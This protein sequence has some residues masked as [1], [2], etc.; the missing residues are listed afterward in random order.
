MTANRIG[1]GISTG[2]RNEDKISKSDQTAAKIK[3]VLSRNAQVWLPVKFLKMSGTT[4]KKVPPDGGYGWVVTCAYALNNV[5]RAVELMN[6]W[7]N[8]INTKLANWHKYLWLSLTRHVTDDKIIIDKFYSTQSLGKCSSIYK[9][10]LGDKII[11]NIS[12]YV[13]HTNDK[14]SP[15]KMR[16]HVLLPSWLTED[17]QTYHTCVKLMFLFHVSILGSGTPSHICLRIS[18][19]RSLRWN[20][21]HR[22]AGVPRDYP[23]PW[24]RHASI[25]LRW[26][27]FA[28]VWV[29]KSGGCRRFINQFRPHF[30]RFVV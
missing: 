27:R 22:I 7:A 20:R 1:S 4:M 15:L 6:S 26:S 28:A 3:S 12:N 8:S 25:V 2:Q 19:S 16:S 17:C 9:I 29:S 10:H 30:D 11:I 24:A 5:S 23:E 18:F 14:E 13:L 21:S